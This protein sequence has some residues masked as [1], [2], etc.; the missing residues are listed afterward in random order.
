M[1]LKNQLTVF[2]I[3]T[4]SIAALPDSTPTDPL[5]RAIAAKDANEVKAL[6]AKDPALADRRN[7]KGQSA[8]IAALLLRDDKSFERPHENVILR[9]VLAAK[10]AR[11][12]FEEAAFGDPKTLGA[13]IER[14]PE[15]V[16]ARHTMGWTALHFAAFAG[17]LETAR[18]LIDR[19]AE[20]D[21]RAKNRFDN[22]PLQVALLTEQEKLAE[23]LIAKGADARAKQADGFTALHE[24]ALFGNERLITMLLAAG[25]DVGAKA[26]EGR[27]PLTE[28]L[29]G[30]H[31]SAAALLRSRGAEGPSK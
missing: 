28:A 9:L 25:A 10:P 21:A 1:K 6:L 27:T 18:L 24:A 29:R 16:K 20:V 11:D 19:G 13:L 5:F 30:N 7:E 22:T 26:K 3:A 8:A 15:L 31:P 4:G 2:V 14:E 23:L 17:N 12:A